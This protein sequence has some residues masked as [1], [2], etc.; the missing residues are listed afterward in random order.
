M[1][2]HPLTI[3]DKHIFN[4]YYTSNCRLVNLNNKRP[5]IRRVASKSSSWSP[6]INYSRLECET[7]T[8]SNL[9]EDTLNCNWKRKS[10]EVSHIHL[11]KWQKAAQRNPLNRE[12]FTKYS[13]F[14][15]C[16][17]IKGQLFVKFKTFQSVVLCRILEDLLGASDRTLNCFINI[18]G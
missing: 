17:R 6:D 16:T 4:S 14:L 12:W 1:K 2:H 10:Q 7:E 3:H 18:R 13:L 9:A 5:L 11:R 15:F 8:L